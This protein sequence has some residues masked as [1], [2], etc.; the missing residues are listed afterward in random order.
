MANPQTETIRQA[1]LMARKGDAEGALKSLLE[2]P[3]PESSPHAGHYHFTLGQLLLASDRADEAFAHLDVAIFRDG[4][5]TER[6]ATW[7]LAREL[8]ERKH[9][10]GSLERSSSPLEAAV[11][12]PYFAP[13]EGLLAV[14]ALV[15]SFRSSPKGRGATG[16]RSSHRMLRTALIAWLIAA[17]TAAGHLLGSRFPRSRAA[18][19]ISLRSGPAEEFISLGT[20]VPGAELRI[21]DRN[22]DWLRVRATSELSGWAPASAVLLLEPPSTTR[23]P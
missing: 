9:G 16:R 23:E 8:A 2:N 13:I 3:I 1:V 20:V 17:G 14:T 5:T 12:S 7:R 11:D 19:E 4:T 10:S 15:L 21:L 22:K 6:E 18:V